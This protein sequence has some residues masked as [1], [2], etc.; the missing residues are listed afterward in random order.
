MLANPTEIAQRGEKIYDEKYRKEY[1]K[2][3]H[4]RFVAID[5]KSEAIYVADTPEAA[6]EDGRKKSPSGVFYLMR[7]GFPGVF[8]VGY[9]STESHG[10]RLLFE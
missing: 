7:V 5:V 8:R 4:G 10:D 6:L 2:K 1:E 9:T 3:H